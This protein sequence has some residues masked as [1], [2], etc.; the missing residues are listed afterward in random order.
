V[1]DQAE[2]PSVSAY[3]PLLAAAGLVVALDQATKQIAL[4]GLADGPVELIPGILDLRL[5]LNPGGAFGLFPGLSGLFLVA[6]VAV[7]AII[8]FW[9]RRLEQRSWAIPLGMILGGGI[10][11]LLDR[12]LRD[13]DGQVVDFIDLQVWPVFNVADTAITLGVLTLVLI[14]ARQPNTN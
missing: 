4:E 11:N 10:G 14:G 12:L 2:R 13:L 3:L 1:S 8:L 9:A 5:T 6:T 7:I